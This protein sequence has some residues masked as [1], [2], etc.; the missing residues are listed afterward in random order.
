[1]DVFFEEERYELKENI[2]HLLG[3]ECTGAPLY[4]PFLYRF[5][6]S[7]C[8]YRMVCSSGSVLLFY[9]YRS[10]PPRVFL[11][12]VSLLRREIV[13][14][15]YKTKSLSFK[16]VEWLPALRS[17]SGLIRYSVVPHVGITGGLIEVICRFF[18]KIS[19]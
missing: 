5:K 2:Y 16:S 6:E 18:E 1:M 12:S 10:T 9:L 3:V 14:H 4:H 11:F 15:G 17:R 19:I 7:E 13:Y 8:R